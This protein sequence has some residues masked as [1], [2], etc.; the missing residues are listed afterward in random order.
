MDATVPRGR[1]SRMLLLLPAWRNLF[2]IYPASAMIHLRL[3]AKYKQIA[4]RRAG[5][6]TQKRQLAHSVPHPL[7]YLHGKKNLGTCTPQKCASAQATARE[8]M[9]GWLFWEA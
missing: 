5:R 7:S 3:Q 4:G 6:E 1:A 8:N 2:Y 9:A